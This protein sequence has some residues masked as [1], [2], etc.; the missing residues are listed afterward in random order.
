MAEKSLKEIVEETIGKSLTDEDFEKAMRIADKVAVANQMKALGLG[1]GSTPAT[2][3][4][5]ERLEN[6]K[7]LNEKQK[8][9]IEAGIIKDTRSNAQRNI[10]KDWVETPVPFTT[11][12]K[13]MYMKSHPDTDVLLRS[14]EEI[15]AESENI[16]NQ[17]REKFWG[18]ENS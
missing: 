12:Q 15:K 4:L 9:L 8:I 10:Q 14:P 7:T 16:K 17:A 5:V 18:K 2:E 11:E 6:C 3:E 1:I 13:R